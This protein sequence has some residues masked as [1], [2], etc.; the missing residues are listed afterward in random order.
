[1]IARTVLG[2]AVAIAGQAAVLGSGDSPRP[3]TGIIQTAKA[4]DFPSLASSFFK[5]TGMAFVGPAVDVMGP[6]PRPGVFDHLLYLSGE[7]GVAWFLRDLR[8][9]KL[10]FLGQQ[11]AA[12]SGGRGL[13]TALHSLLTVGTDEKGLVWYEIQPKTQGQLIP[14]EAVPCGAA[15]EMFTG[16]NEQ[17]VYVKTCEGQ[18]LW[19]RTGYFKGAPVR[20]G[21]EITGKG[22]GADAG[23]CTMCMAPNTRHLYGISV[24]DHAIACIQRKPN[25][26][27]SYQAT[28]DLAPVAKR[29]ASY[30][31]AS[32][33][34][35]PDGHWLYAH[36]WNG[37]AD[38]NCYG[39]FKRQ[40]LT[41]ELTYQETIF[42]NKDALANLKDW[43]VV[44]SPNGVD[45]Y[46]NDGSGTIRTFKYNPQ[47]GHLEQRAAI[48]ELKVSPRRSDV[49]RSS[50][51]LSLCFR[52][53]SPDRL[54][55]TK[56]SATPSRS[57]DDPVE[58]RI[59]RQAH[60][61]GCRLAGNG[62]CCHQ[63]TR[64]RDHDRS[65]H[66]DDRS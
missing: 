7:D 47:T 58:R 12:S 43:P 39:L 20:T 37:N 57:K 55:G 65:A 40:P 28:V 34:L 64:Y 5:P 17:D 53:R 4:A 46:V 19:F 14:K 29:S 30:K 60:G 48:K 13:L 15:R 16:L 21:K 18:L 27:I 11:N 35:S 62:R 6:Y 45:G 33:R 52:W 49:C 63:L 22:L 56:N 59:F 10:H 2:L 51:R 9:G 54:P 1:M 61:H 31:L 42:C 36:L 50:H 25:G 23:S 41:G 3:A 32:I 66:H 38:Q 24:K 44:L 8:T 26:E